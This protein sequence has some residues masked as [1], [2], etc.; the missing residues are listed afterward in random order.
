MKRLKYIAVLLLVAL[1]VTM[2]YAC[3]QSTDGE[4]NVSDKPITQASDDAAGG[5]TPNYDAPKNS[6][7]TY[8]M[9]INKFTAQFPALSL[10]IT[11]V[12]ISEFGTSLYYAPISEA[13]FTEH[14]QKIINNGFTEDA[15]ELEMEYSAQRSEDG[16]FIKFEVTPQF[17]RIA[18][19]SDIKHFDKS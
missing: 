8:E 12:I 6:D 5:V 17:T 11:N 9:P 19:Y 16:Y 4:P 18:V 13:E 3:N 10:T 14:V 2:L 1:M 7:G 15:K